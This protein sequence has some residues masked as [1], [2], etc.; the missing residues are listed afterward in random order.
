MRGR[1]KYL[2]VLEAVQLNLVGTGSSCW[3]CWISSSRWLLHNFLVGAY[4][5]GLRW[6]RGNLVSVLLPGAGDQID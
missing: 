5:G 4:G 3:A 2:G 6:K 1:A